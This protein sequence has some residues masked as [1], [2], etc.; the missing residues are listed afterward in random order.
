M[1]KSYCAPISPEA[2][3]HSLMRIKTCVS[4]TLADAVDGVMSCTCN[5][6]SKYVQGARST[7]V[8]VQHPQSRAM[9][10][11]CGTVAGTMNDRWCLV[12]IWLLFGRFVVTSH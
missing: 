8:L 5:M 10:G 3:G 9:R 2:G 4:C 12:T 1:E 11:R 6:H 7:A